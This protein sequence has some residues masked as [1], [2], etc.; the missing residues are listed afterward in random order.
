MTNL[1]DEITHGG[2]LEPTKSWSRRSWHWIPSP[3]RASGRRDGL[4]CIRQQ[5]GKGLNVKSETDVY[6]CEEQTPEGFPGRVFLLTNVTDDQ[7]PDS[8][9]TFVG[10]GIDSCTCPAARYGAKVCKHRCSIRAL[11]AS[12]A[13]GMRPEPQPDGTCG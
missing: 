6:A 11:I 10:D 5:H 13:I 1:F 12:G 7:S 3:D 8:Y 9:Q 2:E 4:L